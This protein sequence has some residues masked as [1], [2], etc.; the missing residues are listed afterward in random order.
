MPRMRSPFSSVV[1][2]MISMTIGGV[3]QAQN[4]LP[5]VEVKMRNGR[6]TVFIDGKADA[7]PGYSPGTDRAFYDKYMPLFY[8]HKMGVYPIWIEGW[9]V[10]GEN[11]WWA[12]DRV[13]ATPF[14][15]PQPTVFTLENQV[16]HIMRGDPGAYLIVRFY[17]RPPKS[18]SDIHQ[19]EF[20]ITE[21]GTV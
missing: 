7:L 13:S 18:W 8:K 6:P 11:R 17:T 19:N 20:T 9:G 14:F 16:E 5:D 3:I 21:G 2:L 4:K 15:V 10:S 1:C 12:G